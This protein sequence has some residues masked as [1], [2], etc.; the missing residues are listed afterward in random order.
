MRSTL[1]TKCRLCRS[2]GVKLYLKGARCF[3]PKCPL[4]K[5]G[6]VKPGMHGT[7]RSRKPTD[8]GI[9]L[10][11]KQKA[12]RFYGV[13]ETQFKNYYTAA[14]KLKG[15]VGENLLIL[16]ER[17]LDNVVYLSGLCLSRSHAKQLISHKEVLVNGK[18]LN[19]SSYLVKVGDLITL[20]PKTLEKNGDTFKYADK[21]FKAPEWID[22]D[23]SKSSAKI[24]A[25]PIIDQNHNGIDVNLIIEYY[26][27]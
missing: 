9:Q 5:K 4:E 10:R 24:I 22:L 15:L 19:I 2:E 12:K 11:A 1:D 8:Y 21:D 18:V 7:K 25:L 20:K 27:R 16:V 6:A 14:K 3:S 17:R 13:A 26:S 23:K